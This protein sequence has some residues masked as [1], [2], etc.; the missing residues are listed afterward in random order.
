MLFDLARRQGAGADNRIEIHF[1][2][3]NQ[4]MTLVSFMKPFESLSKY[5]VMNRMTSPGQ[6]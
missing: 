3:F 5:L 1:V 2:I 4:L 6:K